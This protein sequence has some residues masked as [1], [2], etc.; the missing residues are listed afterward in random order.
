MDEAVHECA[1]GL[2]LDGRAGRTLGLVLADLVNCLNP[3]AI[4]LGGNLSAAGEPLAEGVRE[5]INRYAQPASAK[6]VT[7]DRKDLVDCRIAGP[8]SKGWW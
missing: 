8:P 5:S 4:I 1:G 3:A 2:P 7:A 6:A